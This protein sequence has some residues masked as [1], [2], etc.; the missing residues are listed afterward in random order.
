M[1]WILESVNG[2][3]RP[4][5]LI[6][7][8]SHSLTWLWPLNKRREYCLITFTDN[9]GPDSVA[10]EV[11]IKPRCQV[12]NVRNKLYLKN[13]AQILPEG[14]TIDYVKPRTIVIRTTL[15]D[16]DLSEG[17]I[18]E[19]LHILCDLSLTIALASHLNGRLSENASRRGTE[20]F[21]KVL[22]TDLAWLTVCSVSVDAVPN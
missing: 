15:G 3:I 6:E 17:D 7:E 16:E 5:C 11:I 8:T 12:D 18:Q 14:F 21:K 22:P 1:H 2:Y 4:E 9:L 13:L 10:V 19:A 20:T